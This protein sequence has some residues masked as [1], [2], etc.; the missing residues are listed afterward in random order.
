MK[1]ATLLALSLL[2]SG[3][4]ALAQG[5]GTKITPLLSREVVGVPG[6]AL[7]MITVEYLPGAADPVHVHNAQAMV[8]VL[9][10]TV[11]MQVKGGAP[12]TLKAGETFYEKPGDV[13]VVARNASTVRPAR[14]VVFFMKDK[15][16]P[17]LV[18]VK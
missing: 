7:E 16:A 9:E 11:V 2:L 6:K 4:T 10:G 12:V 13:H 17:I 18:P 15:D 3:A 5:A 14:F 8:Y 1:H